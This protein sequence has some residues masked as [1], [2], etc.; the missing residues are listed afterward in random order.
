MAIRVLLDHGVRE[1]RI[2]FVTIL[3]A[4]L[5]RARLDTFVSQVV[6]PWTRP[7]IAVTFSLS[8]PLPVVEV[9]T[10]KRALDFLVLEEREVTVQFMITEG[11]NLF[12]N[13]RV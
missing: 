9:K 2:I 7:S 8:F 1:D 13:M 11:S 4:P 5:R 10:L 3:V 12:A 6:D